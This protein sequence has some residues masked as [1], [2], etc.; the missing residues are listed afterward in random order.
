MVAIIEVTIFFIPNLH[1]PTVCFCY[2][3]G[4]PFLID[5]QIACNYSTDFLDVLTNAQPRR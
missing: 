5:W 4:T 3:G 2:G 1:Q